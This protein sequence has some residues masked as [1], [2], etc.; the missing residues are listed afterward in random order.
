[1]QHI[2]ESKLES[3]PEYRYEYLAEFVGFGAD[4]V[5]LIQAAA[6]HIGPRIA[7]LVERTYEKLLSYDATA[8]HFV[9]KQ[10]GFE[11][12]QPV[13]LAE[14]DASHPQIQFRKDHLNRYF[15]ALMKSF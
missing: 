1:M 8:R 7:Q 6:P 9:P 2:D 10:H 14:L 12:D 13:D 11:G 5:K 15:L 3:D 4:D